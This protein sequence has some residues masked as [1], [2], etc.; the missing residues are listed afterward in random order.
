MGETIR[1][2]LP[3]APAG[4]P[5]TPSR[6]DIGASVVSFPGQRSAVVG[7]HCVRGLTGEM[8][9]NAQS[10][11]YENQVDAGVIDPTSVVRVAL[12]NAAS[13]ASLLLTTEAAISHIPEAA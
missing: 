10:E 6:G 3:L 2:S 9:F 1:R 13:V 5:H 7:H 4:T 12:Q 8:C 11:T